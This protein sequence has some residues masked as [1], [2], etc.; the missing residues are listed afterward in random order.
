[1]RTA[2]CIALLLIILSS[3]CVAQEKS[4]AEQEAIHTKYSIENIKG[5]ILL[6]RND[7]VEQISI[8]D[9]EVVID[10]K[11]VRTSSGIIGPGE[12]GKIAIYS[13]IDY[14]SANEVSVKPKDS[15]ISA[16]TISNVTP[17]T[18]MLSQKL[19]YDSIIAY[20]KLDE[21]YG[22]TFLDSSGNSYKGG[23]APSRCPKYTENGRVNGAHVFDGSN[24]IF[25]GTIQKFDNVTEFTIE[26]WAK[27]DEIS[28]AERLGTIFDKGPVASN[29]YAWFYIFNPPGYNLVLE[30]GDKE[31]WA[32]FVAP[33]SSF[34]AEQWHHVAVSISSVAGA[35]NVT[36]Y[37]NGAVIGT[38]LV[39]GRNVHSGN[40]NARIGS[41]QGTSHYF[42][43]ALDEIRIWNRALSGHEIKAHYEEGN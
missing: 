26:A 4:A 35:V 27:S 24:D 39:Y 38:T 41:Y 20:W 22:T 29:Q 13:F 32:R 40:Y 30:S 23:C 33:P 37:K 5:N 2:S 16:G 34:P 19:W 9:L 7:G 14:S 21:T 3:A 1:M 18:S 10:G 36:F 12:L 8:D 15:A 25:I 43:G 6:L 42:K 11:R 28:G 17:S 31:G